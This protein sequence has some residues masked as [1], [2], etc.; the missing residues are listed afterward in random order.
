MLLLFF[1]NALL[2]QMLVLKVWHAELAGTYA[3]AVRVKAA[4]TFI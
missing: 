4:I 1:I 2:T 3:A